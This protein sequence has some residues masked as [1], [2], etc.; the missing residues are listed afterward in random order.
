LELAKQLLTTCR[1]YGGAE[2]DLATVAV[3][4][5]EFSQSLH[6]ASNGYLRTSIDGQIG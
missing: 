6:T 4:G 2:N 5:N 3:M 1:D